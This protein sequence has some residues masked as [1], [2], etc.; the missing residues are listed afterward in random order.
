MDLEARSLPAGVKT[1]LL[2][3]LRDYKARR[4]PPSCT[5]AAA[6]PVRARAQSDPAR[7]WLPAS[8]CALSALKCL[9]CA[10]LQMQGPPGA[11][12]ALQVL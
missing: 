3:K 1:P 9:L 5:Q 2:G 11:Q 7:G 8:G 6:P 12:A 10:V 4:C